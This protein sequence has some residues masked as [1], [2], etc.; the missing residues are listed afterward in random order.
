ML[1]KPSMEQLPLLLSMEPLQSSMEHL[2]SIVY[3]EDLLQV[4]M[5]V[6]RI[7]LLPTP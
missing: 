6:F 2:L 4:L 7:Y 5:V 3:L 1:P